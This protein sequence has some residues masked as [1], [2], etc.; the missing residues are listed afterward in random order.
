MTIN[1]E[2]E[3]NWLKE[4]VY[5][6]KRHR[7]VHLVKLAV[8]SLRESKQKISLSSVSNKSKEIDSGGRGVSESAI[9]NNEDARTYYERYRTWKGVS[10]RRL[11]HK[12]DNREASLLSRHRVDPNRDV[13]RVRQRLMRLSKTELVDRV[14][15]LEQSAGVQEEQWLQLNDELLFWRLRA[16]QAEALLENK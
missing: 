11:K 14:V 6:P 10:R 15:T 13:S 7:T 5:E 8:D 2:S 9:L 16:E 12:A 3:R 1:N 4:K